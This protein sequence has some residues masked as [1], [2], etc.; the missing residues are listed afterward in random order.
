MLGAS[1]YY[2]FQVY[3]DFAERARAEGIFPLFGLEIICMQ[4]DL[5]KAGVKVN[6]PGKT[7][8]CGKVSLPL[9]PSS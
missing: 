2:D 5:R 1:N 9:V 6:D 3:A 8:L 7:Y 4:E